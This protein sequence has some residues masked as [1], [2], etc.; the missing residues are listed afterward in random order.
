MPDEE[1]SQDEPHA[2]EQAGESSA[3]ELDAHD[4]LDDAL[5]VSLSLSRGGPG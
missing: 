4:D 1:S 5:E 3:E 2:A